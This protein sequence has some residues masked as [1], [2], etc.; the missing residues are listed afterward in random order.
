MSSAFLTQVTAAFALTLG[1]ASAQASYGNS[2]TPS[3]SITFPDPTG[4]ST[5][6][7]T[8]TYNASLASTRLPN[9]D[10]SN[11]QLAFLW[12]QVGPVVTGPV[13]TTV[14]PTPEPSAYPNPGQALHPYI[15]SYVSN[16]STHDL[17]TDF[18]WGVAASAY[19]IEVRLGSNL[20]KR[21]Q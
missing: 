15:P 16:L 4:V 18:T 6:F 5:Q 17:P 10:Y 7:S 8:K 14:S 20:E 11:E 13:T 1:Y 3:S 19:Q 9:T 21:S 12:D 2:T